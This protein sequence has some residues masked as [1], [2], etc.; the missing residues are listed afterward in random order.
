MEGAGISWTLKATWISLVALEE[1][2]HLGTQKMRHEKASEW[3]SGRYRLDGREGGV[4][5]SACGHGQAPGRTR[6]LTS[7]ESTEGEQEPPWILRVCWH[8]AHT[9]HVPHVACHLHDAVTPSVL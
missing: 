8:S 3:E 1:E 2:E 6:G 7:W 9:L 4:W 5:L